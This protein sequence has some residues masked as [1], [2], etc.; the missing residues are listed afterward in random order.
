[1]EK[2]PDNILLDFSL[3]I[4]G[5]SKLELVEKYLSACSLFCVEESSLGIAESKEQV[6]VRLC[7]DGEK[8]SS[9]DS[10][11][12][13]FSPPE[14][15]VG[16]I[17]FSRE[18]RKFLSILLGEDPISDISKIG[19]VKN[20]E[21]VAFEK[22]QISKFLPH[23]VERIRCIC[24]KVKVVLH[25]LKTEKKKISPKQIP[26]TPEVSNEEKK[27]PTFIKWSSVELERY[28]NSEKHQPKGWKKFFEKHKDEVKRVSDKLWAVR[29]TKII[30]RMTCVYRA[31]SET[32]MEN[33]K[34]VILGQDPYPTPGNAVGLAF[35]VKKGLKPPQSLKNI[36]EEVK[37][38]GFETTGSGDLSCWAS[39]GVLLLNTAL[40]TEE[41]QK[42]SHLA[43]WAE[44]STCV[45]KY[46]SR[47]R[48]GIVY[49]LWG[50][51]AQKFKQYINIKDNLVLECAHPSPLSVTGFR[52]NNHFVLANEYLEEKINWSA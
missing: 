41:G 14:I 28:T 33:V 12:P 29:E 48:K 20:L 23:A 47:K 21:S 49:M 3:K 9:I 27:K 52:D 24:P 13:E 51:K 31:F 38:Q 17:V 32:P 11:F 19:K 37:K 45:I 40:T 2:V 7:F 39:Q 30:P 42:E 35:S 10:E 4:L 25:P 22:E 34:V 16:K 46:L 15:S 50:G 5:V 8:D 26:D 36:L 1:M 43:V 44:F 18:P 6:I